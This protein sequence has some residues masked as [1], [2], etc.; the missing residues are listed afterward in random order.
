MFTLA[1]PPL[2]ELGDDKLRLLS[3]FT[4]FYA[5]QSG[6]S[7][8]RLDSHA[9]AIWMDYSFPGNVREL[10]NIV[11]RL[12]TRYAGETVN[13]EQLGRVTQVAVGQGQSRVDIAALDAL[14]RIV[15]I[16]ADLR[17]QLTLGC[18]HGSAEIGPE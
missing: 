11:I 9:E 1:M 4:E 3:H 18:F 7:P 13:A 10:R 6:A 2:R 15:Q 5:R 16:E 14:E 8:F 17:L 12:I